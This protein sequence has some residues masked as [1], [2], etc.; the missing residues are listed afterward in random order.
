MNEVKLVDDDQSATNIEFAAAGDDI[1]EDPEENDDRDW[2]SS[3][4]VGQS[5]GR[6]HDNSQPQTMCEQ[7]AQVGMTLSIAKSS[8]HFCCF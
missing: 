8:T 4:E 7:I 1:F 5:F 6:P 3:E 2:V